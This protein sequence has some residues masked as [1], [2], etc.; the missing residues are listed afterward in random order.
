MS[1][2]TLKDLI[3][4]ARMV[5]AAFV[6]ATTKEAA[7]SM[8]QGQMMDPNMG[9]PGGTGVDPQAMMDPYGGTGVDPQAMMDPYGGTGVD[10]Q[11]MMDP[12]GGTGVPQPGM[13]MPPA[14]ITTPVP[15]M[16]DAPMPSAP[17]DSKELDEVFTI[18]SQMAEGIDRVESKQEALEKRYSDVKARMDEVYGKLEMLIQILEGGTPKI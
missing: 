3:K 4:Q 12:Y 16:P 15:P 11:A 1:E 7:A 5:K 6:P 13:E 17:E 9:M 10:P 14:P 2:F 8:P 18:I